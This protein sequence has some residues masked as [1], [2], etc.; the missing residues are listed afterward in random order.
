MNV[1]TKEVFHEKLRYALR[2]AT[3]EMIQTEFV[4]FSI[5]VCTEREIRGVQLGNSFAMRKLRRQEGL[6]GMYC[7]FFS[8]GVLAG[9]YL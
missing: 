4:G 1:V 3:N 2:D 6:I 5:L 9:L 7:L 8:L